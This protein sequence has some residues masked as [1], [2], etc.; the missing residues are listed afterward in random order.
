MP[1]GTLNGGIAAELCSE[2]SRLAPGKRIERMG[3]VHVLPLS[4]RDLVTT[5]RSLSEREAALE[6]LYDTEAVSVEMEQNAIASVTARGPERAQLSGYAFRVEGLTDPDDLLPLRVPYCLAKAVDEREI[7][8]H[9]KFT[10]YAPGDEPDEG[11]CR[12]NL[13]PAREDA[14]ERARSDALLVHRHLSRVLAPFE[15]SEI[16]EMSPRVVDREGPRA[17]GDYTLCS[18]DVLEA[19][20]FPDGV[21]RNAWPIELWDPQRGPSHRYLG[22]GEYHEIPLRCLKVRDIANC[23]CAGRC[24]SATREALGSTRVMGACISTGEEAGRA[25][26]RDLQRTS[27]AVSANHRE[28]R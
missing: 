1:A 5:L 16:M 11:Y 12:L 20:K 7:P 14:D 17:C 25:A 26:A 22:E 10:T 8:F 15:N 24:M 27:R 6:I 21:V 13:P 4:T 2:L 23:W 18:D 19:R 9:L 28:I 3:R